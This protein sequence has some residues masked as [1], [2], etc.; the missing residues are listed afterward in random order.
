[1]N[2]EAYLPAV[3]TPEDLLIIMSA[4]S[5]GSVSVAVWMA[6]LHPDPAVKRAKRMALQR[7]EMRAGVVGP[8]RRQERLPTFGIMRQ[9]VD[10][11]NLLRSAQANKISLNLM[12][13]GWRSKDAIIIYLF[14]KLALPFAVGAALVVMVFGLNL[15]DFTQ[16]QKFAVT[17][18]G[19]IVGAYLPDVI[20][21]NAAA[22]RRDKI[23]KSLPDALDLMV[24]CAEA[25]LS[26]DATLMRVSTEMEQAAAEI[27][28]ELSLTGLELGFLSDRRKALQNLALRVDLSAVRGVANT[29]IQ[30]ERYGTPLAQSLRVMAAESRQ[31]RVMKAEEKAARLPALMTVPMIL[32]ILPP[33][34]IVLL[35]NAILSTMD[36]FTGVY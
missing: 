20:V 7:S 19:V 26:L 14:S 32:F 25:G 18:V 12:R 33:L 28:D 17:L 10:R 23:R 16:I 34:F 22:K 11:L 30:A 13:A 31:E 36:A 24:I 35:G 2:F 3:M 4:L 8:R 5:A 1:M 6:L 15:Y 9:V 27:A 21:R 29:L